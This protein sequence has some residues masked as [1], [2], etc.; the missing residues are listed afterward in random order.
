M[1]DYRERQDEERL[2]L[3]EDEEFTP[4]TAYEAYLAELSTPEPESKGIR[5]K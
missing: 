4:R 1:S 2:Q 3:M 5:L